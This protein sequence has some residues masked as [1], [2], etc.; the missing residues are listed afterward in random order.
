MQDDQS[1]PLLS[2]FPN[3]GSCREQSLLGELI[4]A[5]LAVESWGTKKDHDKENLKAFYSAR[6]PGGL[7]ELPLSSS[8]VF[9]LKIETQ[10][11]NKADQVS[12]FG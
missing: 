10:V 3:R 7:F 6:P 9:K 12:H 4:A 1:L 2:M 8:G 5:V 11:R